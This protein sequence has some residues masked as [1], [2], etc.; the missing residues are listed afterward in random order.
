[1]TRILPVSGKEK[2]NKK[3]LAPVHGTKA[4]ASAIPPKLTLKTPA[5][6]RVPSYAPRWITGGMP[7]GPYLA[8]AVRSALRSPF[9][10]RPPP[11]SHH[12]GLSEGSPHRVL[13]SVI[14]L[15]CFIVVAYYTQERTICQPL[16]RG[17]N[18]RMMLTVKCNLDPL[19][20]PDFFAIILVMIEMLI[21]VFGTPVYNNVDLLFLLSIRHF[22]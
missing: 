22:Y 3:A 7:V 15:C 17:T 5:R 10:D 13:L 4:A 6:L 18:L 2:A 1:M 9:T 14:G 12:Q 16:F 19:Y 21:P 8:R 20:N 11:R